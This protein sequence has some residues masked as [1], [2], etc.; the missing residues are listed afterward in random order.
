MSLPERAEPRLLLVDH[1][2]SFVRRDG[3]P[4]VF[5]SGDNVACAVISY[6][7]R[8]PLRSDGLPTLAVS[9][10]R[11]RVPRPRRIQKIQSVCAAC[12]TLRTLEHA[13]VSKN[14]FKAR[15]RCRVHNIQH[16]PNE[17]ESAVN[18]VSV[19]LLQSAFDIK[20]VIAAVAYTQN[21][22]GQDV[23]FPTETMLKDS[24]LNKRP[25]FQFHF[26]MNLR[27]VWLSVRGPASVEATKR[28]ENVCREAA[29]TVFAEIRRCATGP[30]VQPSA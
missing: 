4:A 14:F 5:K 1:E 3:G 10:V 27:T 9:Y 12:T 23:F 20:D 25:R 2:Q 13:L 29:S 28:A 19:S 11:S 30:L 21:H 15:I 22:L 17:V 16:G 24:K 18:A 6:P 26:D 8:G 7:Q